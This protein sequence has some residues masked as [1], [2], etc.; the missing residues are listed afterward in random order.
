MEEDDEEERSSTS[1]EWRRNVSA[2][3]DQI[4]ALQ[5]SLEKT[6]NENSKLRTIL[7]TQ[8]DIRDVNVRDRREQL[9]VNTKP[10]EV[11][12]TQTNKTPRQQCKAPAPRVCDVDENAERRQQPQPSVER[13]H[14]QQPAIP[15]YQ[16]PRVCFDIVDQSCCMNYDPA[17]MLVVA[18][19][20]HTECAVACCQ[21]NTASETPQRTALKTVNSSTVY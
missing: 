8:S 15:Q 3:Y 13:R 11:P 7:R 2:L 21:Q 16:S 20:Q 12:R 1:E 9:T 6:K 19:Q 14:K 10:P 5:S 4:S 17:E 18:K